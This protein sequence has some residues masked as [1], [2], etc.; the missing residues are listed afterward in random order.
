MKSWDASQCVEG[1][2][3]VIVWCT[4]AW[5]SSRLVSLVLSGLIILTLSSFWIT[6]QGRW[7][8][9]CLTSV[10]PQ[11]NKQLFPA[12]L[13]WPLPGSL[14]QNCSS[15]SSMIKIVK[16]VTAQLLSQPTSNLYS[17]S[18]TKTPTEPLYKTWFGTIKIIQIS[19]TFVLLPKMWS[20]FLLCEI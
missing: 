17:Q 4:R 7:Q 1:I 3:T 14:H 13:I 15:S 2:V 11:L 19:M 20:R 9:S 18:V 8:S 6:S 10:L 12:N 16:Y 5:S